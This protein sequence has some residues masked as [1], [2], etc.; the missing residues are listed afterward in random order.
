MTKQDEINLFK[1]F[2]AQ[3]PVE[4]EYLRSI[5]GAIEGEVADAI[6]NDFGFVSFR[7]RIEEQRQHTKEIG[8]LG[9]KRNELAAELKRLERQRDRLRA[10][11]EEAKKLALRVYQA[12]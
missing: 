1:N 10:D 3:L 9:A 7:E 4:A 11:I 2:V 6:R 8:E 5:L 12:Q